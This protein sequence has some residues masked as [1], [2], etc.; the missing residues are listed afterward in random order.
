MHRSWPPLTTPRRFGSV[1][2]R[3][4]PAWLNA[5]DA[6]VSVLLWDMNMALGIWLFYASGLD[7]G[8]PE[9]SEMD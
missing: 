3:Q 5:P 6:G 7:E 2:F 1:V 9:K 8:R 4:A